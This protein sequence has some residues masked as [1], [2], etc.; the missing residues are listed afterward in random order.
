LE[1]VVDHAVIKTIVH[2]AIVPFIAFDLTA[3]SMV[4]VKESKDFFP[5]ATILDDVGLSEVHPVFAIPELM[6]AILL[7]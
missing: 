4:I 2:G 1:T 7:G 3:E 6:S 5:L